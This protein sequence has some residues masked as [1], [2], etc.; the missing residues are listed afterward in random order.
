MSVCVA[1]FV[2]SASTMTMLLSHPKID[3]FPVIVSIFSCLISLFSFADGRLSC[4]P[5]ANVM[6][7]DTSPRYYVF[8]SLFSYS[9]VEFVG[10]FPFHSMDLCIRFF[11]SRENMEFRL[12]W[13]ITVVSASSSANHIGCVALN[14]L[15]K[16]QN[17]KLSLCS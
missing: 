12:D 11:L 7:D 14:G 10:M 15:A 16:T 2:Q 1:L 17:D 9:I 3:G 6:R 5:P 8:C 4:S 13:E